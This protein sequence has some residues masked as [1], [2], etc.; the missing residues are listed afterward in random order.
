M[1][2]Q[3]NKPASPQAQ[4]SDAARLTK[5]LVAHGLMPPRPSTGGRR[6]G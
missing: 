3:L 5:K 1:E 4:E 6:N 2:Y